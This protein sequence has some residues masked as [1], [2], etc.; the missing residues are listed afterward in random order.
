MDPMADLILESTFIE[1][2]S[3]NFLLFVTLTCKK[4]GLGSE[5]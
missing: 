4:Q 2:D 5:Q 3:P 1:F